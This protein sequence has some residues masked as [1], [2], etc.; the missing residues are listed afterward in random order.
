MDKRGKKIIYLSRCLINQNLRFPGIAVSSGAI[1][2]LIS[3]I[4]ENGIGIESLPCLERI[5]WD[6]LKEALFISISLS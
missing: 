2:E 1:T 4:I 6:V 3:P 5:A